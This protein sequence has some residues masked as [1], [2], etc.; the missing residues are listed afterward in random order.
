MVDPQGSR[1]G[2]FDKQKYRQVVRLL[3]AITC[4]G[5]PSPRRIKRTRLQ[6]HARR[7]SHDIHT[8]LHASFSSKLVRFVLVS[9][10]N[11]PA[12][13]KITCLR[14]LFHKH[15]ADVLGSNWH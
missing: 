7:G 14:P 4:H 10:R 13:T 1:I 5:T 3:S 12:D 2:G 6:Q 11:D 9:R 8:A 15:A